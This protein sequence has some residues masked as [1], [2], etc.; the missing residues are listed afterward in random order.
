MKQ[1]LIV[2]A[3]VCTLAIGCGAV[4]SAQMPTGSFFPVYF[5]NATDSPVWLTVYTRDHELPYSLWSIQKAHCVRPRHNYELDKQSN[6]IRIQV[7]A[8]K[9][10]GD[11]CN[12]GTY[13]KGSIERI[14]D[15]TGQGRTGSIT[16]ILTSHASGA[17]TLDWGTR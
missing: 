17:T 12:T 11:L 13:W 2:C 16:A 9:G 4:A 3:L 1:R 14:A 15:Q 8:Q 5:K 7:E 10:H 6:Q